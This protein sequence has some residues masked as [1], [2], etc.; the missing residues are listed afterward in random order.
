MQLCATNTFVLV[1]VFYSFLVDR[2]LFDCWSCCVLTPGLHTHSTFTSFLGRSCVLTLE[3]ETKVK[4]DESVS[5]SC[6]SVCELQSVH[7][8]KSKSK[9]E[10][11]LFCFSQSFWRQTEEQISSS[12][13][14]SSQNP[15]NVF[16]SQTLINLLHSNVQRRS[17]ML[18]KINVSAFSSRL[19]HWLNKNVLFSNESDF[20]T[21]VCWIVTGCWDVHAPSWLLAC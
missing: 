14:S 5:V 4:P 12:S 8:S 3:P 20:F 13:S 11:L 18:K 6:V 19:H 16:S 15:L 21:A 9:S 10:S 1:V 17:N 7:Q 2:S